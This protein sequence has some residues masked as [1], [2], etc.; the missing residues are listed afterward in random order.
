MKTLL[1]LA[2]A[3]PLLAQSWFPRHNFTV[4]VGAGRPQAEL[5]GPFTDSP[6]MS[7]G[8]G[9]R[10][11]RYLQADVG[12]DSVFGA[13]RVNDY[14]TTDFGDRRIRDYQFLIPF[15]ARAILPLEHGRFLISGGG[16]GVHMRYTELLSQPSTYFRLDCRVC[17]SRSGWGYYGLVGAAVAVDRQQHFRFGVTSKVYQGHTDGDPLGNVPGVRTRDR[18]VN[19]FG[20]FGVSF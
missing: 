20:E 19:V 1:L 15:G 3:G 4:G 7:F 18:W 14:L 6:G 9:Y 16:G 13:A 12:L 11:H 2:A 5:A 17:S 8:Y 10:F